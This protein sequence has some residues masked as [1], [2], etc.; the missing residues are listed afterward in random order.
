MTPLQYIA[1]R[2]LLAIP[3]FIGITLLCFALTRLLPGGPVEMRLARLK[4]IGGASGTLATTTIAETQRQEL[5]RQFGFDQP[6]LVQYTRWL[7]K[8]LAGLRMPSYDYPDRTAW[9]LIRARIPVSCIFGLA[10]FLLSYAICIPLGLA[11]GMRPNTPFDWASGL[12]VLTAYAIPPLTL[13]MI[14]KT[15]FCGTVET[16]WNILPL[17][18][19]ASAT[20]PPDA[21]AWTLFKDRIA[22]M[23]LPVACYVAGNFAVLTLLMRN[24]VVEQISADYLRTAIAK[25]SSRRRAVWHHALRNS[26]IPIATGFGSILG[27]LFAGS[28]IVE[29]VFEL[30]GMGRLSLEALASHDYAVFL[31]ILSLTSILQLAGNLLSDVCY[32]LID[33]RIRFD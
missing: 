15:L 29:T 18:G 25:G 14:L 33:P 32:M 31:A 10:G 21:T 4:G 13:A 11:R 5:N 24:S 12:I 6:F 17:S 9:Q 1:R 22:H 28:V 20:L 26:L 19:A 3:T 16:F 27:V 2:L 8:D 23:V 30:P 7:I